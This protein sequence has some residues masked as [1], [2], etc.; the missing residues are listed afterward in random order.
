MCYP[1][2][3]ECEQSLW[4]RSP[5]GNEIRT[6]IGMLV[7]PPEPIGSIC[8]CRCNLHIP[9]HPVYGVCSAGCF[10]N[11]VVVLVEKWV[12]RHRSS[13]A[14]AR[15]EFERHVIEI[16]QRNQSSK[17]EASAIATCNVFLAWRPDRFTTFFSFRFLGERKKQCRLRSS[18]AG[19]IVVALAHCCCIS[20][21]QRQAARA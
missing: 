8:T 5:K 10:A 19:P 4:Q 6:A 13:K 14:D 3:F 15:I 1:K 7:T 18:S 11:C 20:T 16:G 21:C 9:V 12:V 2:T 17:E